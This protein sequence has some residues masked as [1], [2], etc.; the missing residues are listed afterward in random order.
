M[1]GVGGRFGTATASAL[2]ST[3]IRFLPRGGS[4]DYENPYPVR[5]WSGDGPRRRGDELPRRSVATMVAA[6]LRSK[7]PKIDCG[8]RFREVL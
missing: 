6:A 3:A 2:R 4:R 5:G 1:A 7:G 8:N